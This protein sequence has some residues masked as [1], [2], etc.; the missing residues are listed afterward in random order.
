MEQVK[1]ITLVAFSVLILLLGIY[2]NTMQYANAIVLTSRVYHTSDT[3]EGITY[4]AQRDYIATSTAG[5][6]FIL[7]RG[8]D[9]TGVLN[10]TLQFVPSGPSNGNFD[11]T[12]ACVNH[13]SLNK[14]ICVLGNAASLGNGTALMTVQ[15][16]SP[17]TK[18]NY[19]NTTH[20]G[21]TQNALVEVDT[22][23][24]S[25]V[26]NCNT[27]SKIGVWIIQSNL[28]VDG[29]SAGDDSIFSFPAGLQNIAN[30]QHYN[31]GCY[32]SNVRQV[33]FTPFQTVATMV[34]V[35]T[36]VNSLLAGIDLVNPSTD[37]FCAGNGIAIATSS[38]GDW[39]KVINLSTGT[40][41]G[42]TSFTN[43]TS[44]IKHGNEVFISDAT[45]TITVFNFAQ[46]GAMT[47][48]GT[49][50]GFDAFDGEI[51][52]ANATRFNVVDFNEKAYAVNELPNDSSLPP[53]SVEVCIDTNLNG[54]V[55]LCF[56]D[57]N[58]D[59]VADNGDLGSLGA[60]RSNANFTQ[61][62]FQWFCAFGVGSCTD[63][64]PKTNGVGL[65]YLM[66]LVV[67][68]YAFLV[69]IHIMAITR[70]AKQQVQ[71]MDMLHINPILLLV[72]MIIDLGITW[73]LGW[74]DDAILALIVVAIAGMTTFGFLKKFGSGGQ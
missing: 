23:I 70:L 55:D 57:T 48:T 9:L 14:E 37:I 10:T 47:Q 33:I 27:P 50:T 16:T 18:I 73:K 66:M 58:G 26:G 65:F 4:Y 1:R 32:D 53:S 31:N 20:T 24:Y 51:I 54:V 25:M 6:E 45:N 40:V 5:R 62:G 21:C 30:S 72:M 28:I 42:T 63:T 44:V 8:S 49:I 19:F 71:V 2:S 3:N 39:I 61:V 56:T 38:I 46:T 17:F 52:K 34:R 74:V 11:K 41:T 13:V 67:L 35:N 68:S 43:P 60:F 15:V 7:I 36:A 29:I 22:L 12:I 59:G 64:N 69:F